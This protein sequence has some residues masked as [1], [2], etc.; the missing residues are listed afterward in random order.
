MFSF[1]AASIIALGPLSFIGRLWENVQL[2]MSWVASLL[3]LA[4]QGRVSQFYHPSLLPSSNS[5]LSMPQIFPL[6]LRVIPSLSWWK[7]YR[8]PSAGGLEGPTKPSWLQQAKQRSCT[9]HPLSVVQISP[10]SLMHIYISGIQSFMSHSFH[11]NWLLTKENKFQTIL[12]PRST[13]S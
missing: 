5:I 13:S 7:L 12:Q 4:G 2:I 11:V 3:S 8:W 10:I 6:Q 1:L 9:F